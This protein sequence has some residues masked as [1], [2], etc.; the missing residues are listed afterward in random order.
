MSKQNDQDEPPKQKTPGLDENPFAD[1]PKLSKLFQEYKD[2]I[3]NWP[4]P[5]PVPTFYRSISINI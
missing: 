5:S 2:S 3:P 1:C 4:E